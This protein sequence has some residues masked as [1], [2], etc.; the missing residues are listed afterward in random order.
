M[1]VKKTKVKMLI[2][3]AGGADARYDLPDFG[4]APGQIVELHPKLAELWIAT[5]KAEAAQ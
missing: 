5:G 2:T 4:Y 1:A 3:V